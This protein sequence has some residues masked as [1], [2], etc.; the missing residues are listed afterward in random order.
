[1][2]DMTRTITINI[3]DELNNKFRSRVRQMYGNAKGVLGKAISEAMERW[4]EQKPDYEKKA[5]EHLRKGYNL[6]GTTYKNRD[7]LYE[8]SHRH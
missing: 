7:E 2:F 5:L 4:L 6:G 1:M 3:D 8:R